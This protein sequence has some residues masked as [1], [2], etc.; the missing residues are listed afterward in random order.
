MDKTI[1]SHVMYPRDQ[2]GKIVPVT[3]F[4]TA[5]APDYIGYRHQQVDQ[6]NGKWD[7]VWHYCIRNEHTLQIVD[8]YKNLNHMLLVLCAL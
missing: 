2:R 6:G 4:Q 1:F 5:I 8:E 7:G 3:I